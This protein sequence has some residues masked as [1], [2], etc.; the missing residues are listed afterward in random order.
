MSGWTAKRFWKAA[1]PEP[2]DGG[3]TVRL[4]G[5]AVKTPAK[6]A[7]VVPSLAMAQ[8]AAAEWD[9]QQ[10][11]IKP[12]TMP[13]TRAANSAIDKLSVQFDEVVDLIAAYG[14][15]D[16]LCYRATGPD[17][18]VARQA[19]AWDPLLDWS[20]AELGAA[21]VATAGVIH[22]DQPSGSLARL[23]ALTAALGRFRLAAF[24]DL[25]AISGSLILGF[26]VTRGR[27]SADEAFALSRIDEDWQAEIWGVDE[28]AAALEAARRQAF[29]EAARFYELCG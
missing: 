8:A 7:F 22:I 2:C 3:F 27:L 21:L 17:A 15:S 26:A 12:E 23:H 28:E 14:A 6:A 29:H 13:V 16:L 20:A 19:A 11:V 25:V 24:H 9:A 5:R 1:T 10:G 18:L 4:D